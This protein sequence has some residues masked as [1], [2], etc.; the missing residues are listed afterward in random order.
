[1]SR[2]RAQIAKLSVM[3][4]LKDNMNSYLY[5]GVIYMYL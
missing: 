4:E 1:M 2:K 3:I 5:M